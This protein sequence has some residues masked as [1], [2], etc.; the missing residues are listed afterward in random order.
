MEVFSLNPKESKSEL[1]RRLDTFRRDKALLDYKTVVVE[2]QEFREDDDVDGDGTI[3][4]NINTPDLIVNESVYTIKEDKEPWNVLLTLTE[5]DFVNSE[6]NQRLVVTLPRRFDTNNA[7]QTDF[8]NRMKLKYSA[9]VQ[10]FIKCY[11]NP[12]YTI[13]YNHRPILSKL[14]YIVYVSSFI[15]KS[16]GKSVVD[17][18]MLNNVLESFFSACVVRK[19]DEIVL[20]YPP[21]FATDMWNLINTKEQYIQMWSEDLFYPMWVY[22]ANIFRQIQWLN[23][24]YV[25]VR[26]GV[27]ERAPEL[28]ESDVILYSIKKIPKYFSLEEILRASINILVTFHTNF[29]K[30]SKA[31]F[32]TNDTN[33]LYKFLKIYTYHESKIKQSDYK[34]V[35]KIINSTDKKTIERILQIIYN[36][37]SNL[38]VGNLNGRIFYY[39]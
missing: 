24:R 31:S 1:K 37:R 39:I 7:D 29:L 3:F 20:P 2:Q 22:V 35:S 33:F 32:N 21:V 26:P 28:M 36:I 10:P 18:G 17:R 4:S 6:Y 15:A 8:L 11:N 23:S 9:I 27:F 38:G 30:N 25:F 5:Q 14:K 16:L 12:Y 13:Y 19:P 34:V